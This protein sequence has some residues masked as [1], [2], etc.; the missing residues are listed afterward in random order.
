MVLYSR[1]ILELF[2]QRIVGQDLALREM[3]RSLTIAR[4]GMGRPGRPLAT[5]LVMG[6]TGTGKSELASLVAGELYGREDCVIPINIAGLPNAVGLIEALGFHIERYDALR[7][8]MREDAEEGRRRFAQAVIV[9]H[10]IHEAEP[11]VISA[12]YHLID[13]GEIPLG[14]GDFF[15]LSRA[16]FLFECPY[17][18]S[19]IEEERSASIGFS[20]ADRD[21]DENDEIDEKIYQDARRW[22][23]GAL[24]VELVGRVDRVVVFK[25]LRPEHL[26]T[27]LDRAFSRQLTT[28]RAR[29]LHD[30]ELNIGDELRSMLLEKGARRLHLGARP[31]LRNVRKYVTF[32]LADLLVS[33]VLTPGARISLS[34]TNGNPVV[35]LENAAAIESSTEMPLLPGSKAVKSIKSIGD[36][37]A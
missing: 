16:I 13:R 28:L 15:D 26:G 7:S 12:L 31:L 33:G 1:H 11:E 25:R 20:S 6:P 8:E 18:I 27:I 9:I 10:D 14:T 2:R 37:A 5:Y 23:E 19:A 35:H 4:G 34:V 24:P 29:G 22:V 21:E 17:G 3:A 36:S 32:P 30:V